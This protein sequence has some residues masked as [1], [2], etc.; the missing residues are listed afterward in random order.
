MTFPASTITTTNLSS[1]AADP[2]VARTDLYNAVVALN[3][4]ISEKNTA[5]GVVVLDSNGQVGSS[6]VPA[7]IAPTGQLTL[8]PTNT[9]VK[10]EDILRLQL[11]PKSVLLNLSTGANPPIAGDIA[12]GSDVDGGNPALC[13]Y[14]GTDWKYLPLASF[15]TVA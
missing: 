11:I 8:Q 6:M 5:N 15:T 14:N 1:G 9:V 13:I 7:I 4:I 12:L 3:T 2:S 10:V